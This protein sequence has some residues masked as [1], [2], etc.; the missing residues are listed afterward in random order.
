[1]FRQPH[2]DLPSPGAENLRIYFFLLR[3]SATSKAFFGLSA[4]VCN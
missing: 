2:R 4:A 1:V 3:L